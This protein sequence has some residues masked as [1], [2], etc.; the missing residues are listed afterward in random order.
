VLALVARTKGEWHCT[1]D[2]IETARSALRV[3]H[4]DWTG[5]EPAEV[6]ASPLVGAVSD[7]ELAQYQEMIEEYSARG[8]RLLTVLDGDYPQNLRLVY[9]RPPFVWARGSLL[10][11]DSRSIAVVGTRSAS[12]E[13]LEQARSLAEQLAQRS[14]TVLSG[15]ALGVDGAAH[16]GALSAGGRTVAVMGTGINTVYPARHAELAERIVESGGAL[17]SQFWPDAPP[18]KWSFPVRNV[19]M[20]GMGVGTVVVEASKTSGAKMQARLALEH[21]KR[22]FLVN[23]L[24]LREEWAQRYAR[25]PGT[26]VVDSV[27]DVVDVLAA[28]ARPVDQLVLG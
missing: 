22:L 3:V 18:T 10:G 2:V 9:N 26:T 23:T 6:T 13:G 8:V 21:G 7:A 16:E 4:G 19:V 28:L 14:V 5:F 12:P 24:V 1:A 17:V 25:H 11:S 20:S 15:L 27:D